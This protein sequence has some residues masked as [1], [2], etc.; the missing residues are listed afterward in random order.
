MKPSKPATDDAGRRI[1]ADAERQN[2]ARRKPGRSALH[3]LAVFGMVGW[4]VALPTVAGALLGLWLDDEQ[5]MGF[6]WTISLV[7]L[8][9]VIG[10][11]LAW[12]WIGR[13]R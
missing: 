5:P 1:A 12:H 3:G 7:V 11:L 9:A 13:E 2:S 10:A 8:G 4:S 6:S